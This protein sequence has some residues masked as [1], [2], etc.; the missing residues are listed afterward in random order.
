M[1]TILQQYQAACSDAVLF[2]L[3]ANAKVE[4]SGPDARQFL[5]NICTNDVK[6]LADGSGCEAFLTTA[7][8]R[9]I[10]HVFV[11][12]YRWHDQPVIWLDTVAGQAEALTRHLNH[13]IISEQVEVAD[14][15]AAISMHRAAGPGAQRTLE[16]CFGCNLTELKRL[17]HQSICFPDGGNGFIRRFDGLSVPA[18][19]IIA[20]TASWTSTVNLELADP[21]VHDILRIEAGLPAFGSDIDENRLVME[22]GRAAQAISYTK[23]CFLGQEPIVMARD[24]GQVNRLLLGV[25]VAAGEPLPRGTR[26]FKGD[27]E[28]GLVTSSVRS[29]RL[30][31]VIALAYLKRGNQEPGLE[32]I[33]EPATDGRQ[34]VVAALPS[35]TR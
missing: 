17:H 14:R 29:P 35:I 16:H 34:A 30:G 1:D 24:R 19:D 10:A 13:Y 31:Q 12:H 7:K 6:N 15:T 28:I 22:V 33:V 25:K 3:S 23:G 9:V 2:D 27:E 20:A 21:Q 18:F 8:A 5:H 26:L 11:G 4:L 32:M